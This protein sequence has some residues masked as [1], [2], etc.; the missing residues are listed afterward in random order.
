M[1]ALK[2][3]ATL[4]VILTTLLATPVEDDW[5]TNIHGLDRKTAD[6]R[7]WCKRLIVAS[8]GLFVVIGIWS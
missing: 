6:I 8:I 7:L 1:I 3:A 4:I 5:M 2:I